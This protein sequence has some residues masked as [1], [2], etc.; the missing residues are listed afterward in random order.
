MNHTN[1]GSLYEAFCDATLPVNAVHDS[2][3]IPLKYK[4]PANKPLPIIGHHDDLMFGYYL[5]GPGLD[6][7]AVLQ[8]PTFQSPKLGTKSRNVT[9]ISETAAMFVQRA[10][11]DRKARMVVDVSSNGGGDLIE[12]F[13]LASVFFPDKPIYTATRFRATELVN[14]MGRVYNSALKINATSEMDLDTSLVAQW[15]VSPD[16]QRNFDSWNDLYG[17][18]QVM[19]SNMST[20]HASFN[21]SQKLEQNKSIKLQQTGLEIARETKSFAPNNIIIVMPTSYSYL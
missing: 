14:L 4:T 12:G 1:G 9:T 16:Q 18:H 10:V 7:V 3:T 11:A 19:N 13:R 17:P 8:V 20:L 2:P 15:T 6:D 5:D 21:F